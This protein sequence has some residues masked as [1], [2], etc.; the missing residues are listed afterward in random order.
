M[1]AYRGRT[2]VTSGRSNGAFDPQRTSGASD[3]YDSDEPLLGSEGI[4]RLIV[5][6]GAA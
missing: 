1:S 4:A 3:R 6:E 5:A 2:E